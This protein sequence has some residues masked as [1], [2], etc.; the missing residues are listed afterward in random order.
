MI[1]YDEVYADVSSWLG[2]NTEDSVPRTNASAMAWEGNGGLADASAYLA[3]KSWLEDASA[4]AR[5]ITIDGMATVAGV[6]ST[7]DVG[8]AMKSASSFF[9]VSRT[10]DT[11]VADLLRTKLGEASNVVSSGS[12]LH[13]CV[14]SCRL[15]C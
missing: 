5:L 15:M 4:H 9:Q 8:A 2:N 11:T 12:L 1:R 6:V 10:D 3:G 7:S 14:L 13:V